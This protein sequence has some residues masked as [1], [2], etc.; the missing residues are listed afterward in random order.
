MDERNEAK[1]QPSEDMAEMMRLKLQR[2]LL[3]INLL[4]VAAG[5]RVEEFYSLLGVSKNTFTDAVTPI[6]YKMTPLKNTKLYQIRK[7]MEVDLD[8]LYGNTM[9]ELGKGFDETFW[10]AFD[11][12]RSE[13]SAKAQK[14]YEG[15]KAESKAEGDKVPPRPKRDEVKKQLKKLYDDMEECQDINL[16]RVIW[17]LKTNTKLG[18][19]ACDSSKLE[20]E[21]KRWL[22]FPFE[23]MKSVEPERLGRVYEQLKQLAYKTKAV[24]DFQKNIES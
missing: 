11:K 7:K 23:E 24:M 12:E 8:I 17:Y 5:I 1:E 2:N 3:I 15:K 4:Y 16:K 21:L 9:F 13:A 6:S 19:K 22:K 10:I 20:E 18:E 14:T